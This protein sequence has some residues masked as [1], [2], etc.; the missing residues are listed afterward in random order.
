MNILQSCSKKNK[1]FEL[2]QHKIGSCSSH[3]VAS[4]RTERVPRR[5]RSSAKMYIDSI[6]YVST[7]AYISNETLLFVD[8]C[9]HIFTYIYL[10]ILIYNSLSYNKNNCCANITFNGTGVIFT[11]SGKRFLSFFLSTN[12]NII[13]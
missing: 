7:V 10:Y 1:V 8:Q 2:N 12:V 4:C 13:V 5:Q 6:L 11:Y 9:I 3:R